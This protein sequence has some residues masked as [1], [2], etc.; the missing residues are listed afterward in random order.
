MR[1]GGRQE[2]SQIV[3]Y[4]NRRLQKGLENLGSAFRNFLLTS[5]FLWRVRVTA[6]TALLLLGIIKK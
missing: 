2:K 6:E 1:E 5:K 4:S 3:V